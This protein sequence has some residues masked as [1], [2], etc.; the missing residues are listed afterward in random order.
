MHYVCEE[1]VGSACIHAVA[2][3]PRTWEDRKR[4]G[5]SE[6]DELVKKCNCLS[7]SLSYTASRVMERSAPT[8]LFGPDAVNGVMCSYFWAFQKMERSGS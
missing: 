7:L 1:N 4:K 6:K 3:T 2:E 8:T 5:G